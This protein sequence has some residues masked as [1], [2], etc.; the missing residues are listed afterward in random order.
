[1]LAEKKLKL[2]AEAEQKTD[3][4]ADQIAWEALKG[5]TDA[6]A[7]KRFI[8]R[9]PTSR[10][11]KD[12][13][14]QVASLTPVQNLSSSTMKDTP[15][16]KDCYLLAG[17]PQSLK[18]FAGVYLPKI[19]AKAALTACAQA[20]NENP[21][22]AMLVNLLGRAHEADRNY[23]EAERNYQKAADLGDM[24]AETNLGW[25]SVYGL[26]GAVD[27]DKGRRMFQKAADA[28]NHSGQ[29]SLAFLY[30]DGYGGVQQDYEKSIELYTKS[31]N[32]GNAAA[33]GNLGWFYREGVGVTRDYQKS[34]EYYRKGA[35][36][37][38][39]SSIAAMGY[40]AQNGLGI[41]QNYDQAKTWYEKGAN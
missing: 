30:R 32:Q 26:N 27:V 24:Y 12:A 20:V 9:Y 31:A 16:A 36:A 7:L 34:V 22:D 28:G 19:D 40:A 37:G 10:Y 3:V 21:R 4:S 2:L 13:E 33:L 1:M 23:V 5:S 11:R 29:A 18:G 41:P 35:D 38:D 25:L 39:L 14:Q 15:A 17:E 8:E 6:A